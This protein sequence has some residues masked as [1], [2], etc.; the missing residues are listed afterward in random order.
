MDQTQ[1]LI[2]IKYLGGNHQ[3]LHVSSY[4]VIIVNV[5]N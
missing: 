5:A 3:D 4:E 2:G 1:T